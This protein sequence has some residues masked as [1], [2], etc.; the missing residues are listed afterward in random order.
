MEK[1]IED[2]IK[3]ELIMTTGATRIFFGLQAAN[4]RLPSLDA[5]FIVKL[6]SG[7]VGGVCDWKSG[8]CQRLCS[9][10]KMNQRVIPQQNFMILLRVI[11]LRDTIEC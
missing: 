7:R 6:A 8:W 4:K 3:D 9:L 2:S 10:Q 11:K 1:N 5:M